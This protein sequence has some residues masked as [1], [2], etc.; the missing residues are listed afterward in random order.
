MAVFRDRMHKK[1][2]Y[3][4]TGSSGWV[5]IQNDWYPLEEKKDINRE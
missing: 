1:G 2:T 3:I 5:L 4:K